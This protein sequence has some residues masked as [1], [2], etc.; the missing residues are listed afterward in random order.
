MNSLLYEIYNGS[1]DV[2]PKRGKEQQEL[3]EKLCEEWEKVRTMFGD[4]FMDRIFDLEGELG[5]WR[6]FH[7]YRAGFSLGV[8][9]VLEAFTPV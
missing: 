1:Y 7:Y 8:R 4:E 2:T 9:L 6:A 3:T 5:D